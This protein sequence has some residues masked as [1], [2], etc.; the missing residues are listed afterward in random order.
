MVGQTCPRRSCGRLVIDNDP[1]AQA[2]AVGITFD[3][4]IWKR[5]AGG[6]EARPNA[7]G[8]VVVCKREAAIRRSR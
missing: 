5:E 3:F 4:P 8:Y 7:I 6:R 2:R 1:A